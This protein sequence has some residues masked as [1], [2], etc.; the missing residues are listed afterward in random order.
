M[1]SDASISHDALDRIDRIQDQL[2]QIS[3][4][5]STEVAAGMIAHEIRNLLT[6]A[7]AYTQLA[8]RETGQNPSVRRALEHAANSMHRAC[9]VAE[10]VLACYRAPIASTG[11][12]V[13][14]VG[15]VVEDCIASLVWD[16]QHPVCLDIRVPPHLAAGI[17]SGALRHI[18]LNLLLNAKAALPNEG[19]KLTITASA[20][21]SSTWNDRLAIAITDDGRGM[22]PHVLAQLR[23]TLASR[24]PQ[25]GPSHGLGLLLCQQ[26]LH[27]SGGTLQ[28]DSQKG[29]GTT[30][31]ITLP[32]ASASRRAQHAA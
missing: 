28:I 24:K 14:D 4:A 16:A 3:D 26:L 10:L 29:A 9:E 27:A 17:S 21:N 25:R 31:L 13:C 11:D 8:L 2:D 15:V 20:A 7:I 12:N 32:I 30:A 18:I 6:P 1:T 5:V 23:A 19:G 22:T